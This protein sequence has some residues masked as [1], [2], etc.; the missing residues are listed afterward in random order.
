MEFICGAPFALVGLIVLIHLR[1]YKKI[2]QKA[3]WIVIGAGLSVAALLFANFMYYCFVVE[4]IYIASEDGDTAKVQTLMAWGANPKDQ[5]EFG[6]PLTAAVE[7]G[8]ADVVC[9]LLA[10]GADPNARM[11]NDSSL[12]TPSPIQIAI[13]EHRPDIVKMLKA[14][15]GKP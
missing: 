5:V 4:G 7:N 6:Y 14:A 9:I 12:Q 1:A 3:F 8:H 10:H 2:S 15:G 11:D 13:K